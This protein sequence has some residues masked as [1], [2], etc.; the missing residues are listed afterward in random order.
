MTEAQRLADRIETENYEAASMIRRLEAECEALRTALADLGVTP[1]EAKAGAE[2]SRANKRDAERY[3]WLRSHPEAV[4]V[5]VPIHGD[6]I[7][8][9]SEQLDAAVDAAMGKEKA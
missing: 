1:E 5:T 6:W 3:R 7:P 8:A 2:R 9:I 4:C